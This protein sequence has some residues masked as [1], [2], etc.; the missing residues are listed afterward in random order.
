[1]PEGETVELPHSLSHMD[2]FDFSQVWISA[3]DFGIFP[4]RLSHRFKHHTSLRPALIYFHIDIFF[5]MVLHDRD[6]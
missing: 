4:K 5:I 6:C 3:I 2:C 1:M